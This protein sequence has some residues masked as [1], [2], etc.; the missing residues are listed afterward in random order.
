MQN[1]HRCRRLLMIDSVFDVSRFIRTVPRIPWP[2][3]WYP[4]DLLVLVSW[5][6]CPRI[7]DLVLVMIVPCPSSVS[8]VSVHTDHTDMEAHYDLRDLRDKLC[9]PIV[10]HYITNH[11]V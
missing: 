1:S 9:H 8:G 2:A 5:Y 4:P 6:W 3:R 11:R 10:N 7:H